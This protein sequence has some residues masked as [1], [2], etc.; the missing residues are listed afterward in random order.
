[1]NLRTLSD[2]GGI[3]AL[4]ESERTPLPAAVDVRSRPPGS[5]LWHAFRERYTRVRAVRELRTPDD[6]LLREIALEDD[7]EPVLGSGWDC[8]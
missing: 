2:S 4:I 5:S 3:A 8:P 1:M 6:R 7:F